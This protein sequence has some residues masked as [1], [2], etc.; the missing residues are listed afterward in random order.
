[1][2]KADLEG[3]VIG[4]YFSAH[5]CPPCRGFTPKLVEWYGKV[6]LKCEMR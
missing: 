1:M 2:T 3:K 5:W 6:K 4:I